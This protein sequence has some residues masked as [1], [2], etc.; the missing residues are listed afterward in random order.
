MINR[1]LVLTIN[2]G[3][4]TA[5]ST[6][7]LIIFVRLST[8]LVLS[9]KSFFPALSPKTSPHL[10]ILQLHHLSPLLQLRSCQLEFSRLHPN[11]R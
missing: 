6:L 3:L 8:N 5:T 4:A 11:R 2:T 7:L 9:L 1:L 10:R